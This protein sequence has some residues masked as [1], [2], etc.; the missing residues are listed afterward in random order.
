[1]RASAPI[2]VNL[3]IVAAWAC[4][5]ARE[6]QPARTTAFTLANFQMLRWLE[7]TWRGSEAG[8]RPFFEGYHFSNDTLLRILY[9]ADSTIT[10][11]S[12][13]GSVYLSGGSIYHETG[14]GVWRAIALD[15]N[16]IEFEP[17]EGVNNSF[18]WTR[19]SDTTWVA[20]LRFPDSPSRAYRLEKWP[21]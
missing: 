8:G 15:T 20:T 21:R 6:E 1:M 12:D 13:S 5:P 4:G 14:G 16:S 2:L 11:V 7:G 10:Q 18:S 19:I 17:H 3:I 9:Y